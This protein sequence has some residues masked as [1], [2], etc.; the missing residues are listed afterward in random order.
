[1]LINPLTV[2]KALNHERLA[3]TQGEL[4]A[5]QTISRFMQEVGLSA[6][7]EEFDLTTSPTGYA[8]ITC[9]NKTISAIPY[10]L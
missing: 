6:H 1:M 9:N 5:A 2:V 8:K 7:I 10:G 3:G 4:V